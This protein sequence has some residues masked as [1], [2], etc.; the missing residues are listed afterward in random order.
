MAKKT[1]KVI[2]KKTMTMQ[3]TVCGG[4]QSPMLGSGGRL[5]R[6]SYVCVNKCKDV[7]RSNRKEYEN[8]RNI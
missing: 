7:R 5:P 3:C 2:D 4:Q 6:N 8:G 1:M